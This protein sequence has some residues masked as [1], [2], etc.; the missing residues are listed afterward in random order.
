MKI[1]GIDSMVVIGNLLG[2]SSPVKRGDIVLSIDSVPVHKLLRQMKEYV[3]T[4]GYSDG[5]KEMAISSNFPARFKWLYGVPKTTSIEYLDSTRNKKVAQV[6][7][8]LPTRTQKKDSLYTMVPAMAK[9][10]TT[11]K[12][13]STP[14]YGDFYIDTVLQAAILNLN[15]F[16]HNKV[17]SLIRRSFR[18]TQK[19]GLGNMVIDLRNNGG[20][21]IDNSTL[22]TRFV[23]DKPFR[24]ADSVSAKDLRLAHRKHTQAAWVYRYFRWAFSK[25]KEDGRWH[26]SS[27]ERQI[28]K[29]KKSNHFDGQLYVLTSGA[30]FSAS[31]LFLTK[32]Y[33]QQ[34]VT[35]IGDETGGGARGN[36]AV[37]VPKV[38]LPNTR[39]QLR[40]PLFRI[41]TN[42]GLPHNGR[43]IMPDVPVAV[44]SYYIQQGV[45]KKMQVVK[46]LIK[47]KT[48]IQ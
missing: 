37:L 14:S 33:G 20:G 22:L 21:K 12:K 46:S 6:P 43:G 7:A 44:D 17:P 36:S 8:Y 39:V 5:F 18:E 11:P 26:I 2:D 4:D 40:L 34:N 23:V 38:T 48:S 25:R 32:V 19:A 9:M 47:E 10:G 15:N 28:Y 30:T 27:T 31:T 45:D 29:P 13:K 41:V 16:S 1:W 24:I 3:S 42:A 35:V